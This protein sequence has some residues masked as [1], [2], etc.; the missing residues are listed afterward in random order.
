MVPELTR[1][2]VE[3]C[4]RVFEQLFG[5]HLSVVSCQNDFHEEAPFEVSGIIGITGPMTG[6]VV[7]SFTETIAQILTAK[8]FGYA[9]GTRCV[10]ADVID[11]VGEI[12]NIIGGHFLPVLKQGHPGDHKLSLPSIVVGRHR[13]IWSVRELPSMTI[14]FDSEIGKLA[15]AFNV[16]EQGAPQS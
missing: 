16:R 14:H 2:Y 1:A 4:Q 3:L 9:E 12:A 7:V 5:L 8:M 15:A 10:E 11:C 6:S 13:V